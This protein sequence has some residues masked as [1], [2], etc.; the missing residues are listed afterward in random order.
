MKECSEKCVQHSVE[1]PFKECKNWIDHTEDY[2]CDL[3]A[4]KKNGPMTLRQVADRLGVSFVR[5]KQIEDNAVKKIKKGMKQ[6]ED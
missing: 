2:N 1:C 3:I 5:I 4:I 6:L